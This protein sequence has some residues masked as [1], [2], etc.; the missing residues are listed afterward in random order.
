LFVSVFIAVYIISDGVLI[1][2]KKKAFL[3]VW[4]RLVVH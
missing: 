4:G 3:F 2:T 1:I